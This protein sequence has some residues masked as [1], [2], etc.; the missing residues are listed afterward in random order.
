MLARFVFTLGLV[1]ILSPLS[2]QDSL[3]ARSQPLTFKYNNLQYQGFLDLPKKE[4]RGVI[5]LIPGSGKTD[6]MGKG[7]FANF[8]L[9]TRRAFLNLGYGVYGW[10][11]A[12]CG[13]SEGVFKEDQTIV[14]S[15]DEAISAINE[16]QRQNIPGSQNI[17]LWGIS[18]GGWIC[19]MI[20]EQV[21]SIRFWISVS[22][23]DRYDN[24][25]YLLRTNFEIEG[26]D[27]SMIDTLMRQWDFHMMA[28]RTDTIPYETY[29]KSTEKLYS[30][31][32]YVALGEKKPTPSELENIRNY[33][34]NSE[35]VFD[36][37]TGTRIM[38]PNFE[39]ILAKVT[40]PVLAIFGEDD[41]QIDWQKTK[42]QY[43]VTI[44]NQP[45]ANL[46][47]VSIPACNH[48][49]MKCETGGMFENLEKFNY[50]LCDEYY[51][52]ML[53]WLKQIQF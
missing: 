2:A 51:T 47:I 35:N 45:E 36:K 30:D 27:Q 53:N 50:E 37:E 16:I 12:G 1:C 4:C 21:P 18:R 13:M 32:F 46:Q 42:A 15:R 23:T 43:E 44:G 14:S 22:G 9:Q 26:R 40:C 39:Q 48:L 5:V 31:P 7:G 19:P 20:I 24:Y 33:L 49:I 6:F 29:I 41:S 28:I 34:V 52:E 38:I 25:R 3:S 17:G 8:F 11:K 10:D